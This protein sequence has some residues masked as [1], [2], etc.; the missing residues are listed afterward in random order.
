[1][2]LREII[3]EVRM[4][5]TAL[6]KM[7]SKVEAIAGIEFEM[8]CPI[9]DSGDDNTIESFFDIDNY[10][11]H[12]GVKRDK[13]NKILYDPE[14]EYKEWLTNLAMEEFEKSITV[15]NLKDEIETFIRDTYYDEDE[16]QLEQHI[17]DA[18]EDEYHDDTVAAMDQYRYDQESEWIDEYVM[19]W[20]DRLQ[21]RWF[22][23]YKRITNIREFEE[24]YRISESNSAHI[25]E[26][27]DDFRNVV[28]SPVKVGITYHSV[29]RDGKS[30]IVE[31]DSTLDE[32][33]TD[34]ELGLEFVS[35]PLPLAKMISDMKDIITWASS[36]GCYTNSSCGL[37]MNVSIEGVD[38]SKLD[39]VKLALFVGEDYVLDQFGRDGNTYAQSVTAKLN[40]A[41][42]RDPNSAQ[43]VLKT[44]AQNLS[45]VASKSIHDGIT[46]HYDGLNMHDKYVEFRYAGN[47]W[48]NMEVDQLENTLNRYVTAYG[49]ACDPTAYREEYAKKLYKL[50]SQSDDRFNTLRFFTE[51]V[52]GDL[53][54]KDLED[55]VQQYQTHRVTKG[56]PLINIRYIIRFKP[57]HEEEA[58]RILPNGAL[59]VAKSVP[60]AIQKLRQ[61][62]N[63]G[64]DIPDDWF[65][66]SVK[67]E[68]V[69]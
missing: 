2:K 7:A 45:A 25:V 3:S 46:T 18:L 30:Y 49:I 62:Y 22:S 6:G 26:I 56:K 38:H 17:Q 12:I 55:K 11:Q 4:T 68:A 41:I 69:N 48:L 29:E 54:N 47:D 13:I 51:Y 65:S 24:Q 21:P 61:R 8:Y 1:M 64:V 27:A 58:A 10:Y 31:P 67:K 59:I 16:E 34:E 39:Y 35:P 23:I 57:E 43:Q 44:M 63:I 36:A 19:E 37:H 20:Y 28:D 66:V 9:P 40:G 14:E 33:D 60:E 52:T 5:P 42:G 15:S 32:M 50:I 53:S